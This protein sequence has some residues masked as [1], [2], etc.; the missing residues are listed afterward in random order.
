[1]LVAGIDVVADRAVRDYS[2]HWTEADQQ[3]PFAMLTRPQSIV[4]SER[5]ARRHGLQ[6]GEP[7]HLHTSCGVYSARRERPKRSVGTLRLWTSPPHR[8]YSTAW[9]V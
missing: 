9:A 6:P 3:E 2:F 5:F 8:C 7:L 4:L 1:M